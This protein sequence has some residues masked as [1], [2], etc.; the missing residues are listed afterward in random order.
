LGVT[1]DGWVDEPKKMYATAEDMFDGI[2]GCGCCV[3]DYDN[4]FEDLKAMILKE[5]KQKFMAHY[6]DCAKREL[7]EEG[8]VWEHAYVIADGGYKA[9]DELLYDPR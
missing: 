3:D 4:G 8:A 9:G 6:Y 7:F 2:R 1:N 5:L